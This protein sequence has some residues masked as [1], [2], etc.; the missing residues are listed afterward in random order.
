[1][2]WCRKGKKESAAVNIYSTE[3]VLVSWLFLVFICYVFILFLTF[4]MF[5]LPSYISPHDSCI[6]FNWRILVSIFFL[7]LYHLQG[8]NKNTVKKGTVV[9]EL[10]AGGDSHSEFVCLGWVLLFVRVFLATWR[11]KAAWWHV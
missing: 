2:E 1:M 11:L 7:W 8:Q 4:L 3:G 9:W 10:I 6:I 5:S